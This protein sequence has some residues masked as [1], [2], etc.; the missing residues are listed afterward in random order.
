MSQLEELLS[1]DKNSKLW[2]LLNRRLSER[3]IS[4]RID[5][6]DESIL[7]ERR[8]N[9][10]R[11]GLYNWP[12]SLPSISGSGNSTLSGLFLPFRLGA[13]WGLAGFQSGGCWTLSWWWE[14]VKKTWINSIPAS[15]TARSSGELSFQSSCQGSESGWVAFEGL[16]GN[17]NSS[18]TL[19]I[20]HLQMIVCV[21]QVT[22]Q[23]FWHYSLTPVL[24]RELRVFWSLAFPPS[25][26][27]FWCHSP[28]AS[29]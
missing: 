28:S 29:R 4:N 21:Q 17:W 19:Q 12:S 10:Q 13:S 18:F 1:N 25:L 9:L 22:C 23:I 24:V 7:Y 8:T 3:V 27:A 16:I 14:S 20:S 15:S 26:L 11:A 2:L 6:A 5:K